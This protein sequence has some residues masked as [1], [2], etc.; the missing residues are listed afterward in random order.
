MMSC[1]HCAATVTTQMACRTTLGYP[2]F[3]CRACRRTCNE[4]TG[5]PFNYLQAST[6]VAVLVVLWRLQDKL[7]LRNVAEMFL[8]R[9]FTV[10]HETAPAW[11][12]RFAPLL[13]AQLKARRRG[14]A[15][16]TWHVDEPSVKVEGRWC[17]L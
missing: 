17:Y 13:T 11:E 16:R 2:M 14:K 7:S 10:T 8:T 6:D 15:G 12:E 5:A 3:R 1:P 9:G 4:R